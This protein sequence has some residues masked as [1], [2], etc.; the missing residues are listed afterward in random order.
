[1][2]FDPRVQ[3]EFRGTQFSSDR[4]FLVKRELDSALGLLGL[5]SAALCDNRPGKNKEMLV[6]RADAG[7]LDVRRRAAWGMAVHKP[8][9]Q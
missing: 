7:D 1:V 6:Q 2:D 4:G 8:A 9:W 3:L 5:A